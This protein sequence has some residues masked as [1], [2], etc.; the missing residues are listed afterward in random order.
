ML[1]QD[2]G[3]LPAPPEKTSGWSAPAGH[4]TGRV[5][6]RGR[7]PRLVRSILQGG[8]R[9][10]RLRPANSLTVPTTPTQT[11]CRGASRGRGRRT[12][13][14]RRARR[15]RWPP[16]PPRDACSHC[17]SGAVEPR[18]FTFPSS[19]AGAKDQSWL[20]RTSEDQPPSSW[21]SA[22]PLSRQWI[23]VG[24]P[25]SRWAPSAQPPS[26]AHW[27]TPQ[28]SPG[29]APRCKFSSSEPPSR[30]FQSCFAC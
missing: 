29:F 23:E 12:R 5:P 14:R 8:R 11:P 6:P 2:R 3:Q 16:A 24:Q 13:H 9:S 15:R 17:L 20:W 21:G 30:T 28:R 4:P 19:L 10:D 26:R 25:P 1:A 18:M 27:A 22:A 7:G